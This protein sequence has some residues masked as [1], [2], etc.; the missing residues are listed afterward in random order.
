MARFLIGESS[1]I[2]IGRGLPR[3]LLPPSPARRRVAVLHQARSPSVADVVD[4][5]EAGGVAVEVID[6]PGGEEAKTLAAVEG[7]Y[8]RLA[9]FE[10]GRSDTVVTVGGGATTDAG[11]FVAATWLRGIEVVHVPTTL[12]AAVDAAIGGKTAVNLGGKNLVGAFWHPRRV[13]ID[14][15][16]LSG[17]PAALMRQGAAEAIKAGLIGAP[18]LVEEYRIHGLAAPL[19]EVVPP[20]VRVKAEIVSDDFTER[21]NRAWLNLGHTIG[22][23]IEFASGLSHGESVAIGLVA[24][25]AVSERLLGFDQTRYVV[26]TLERVGLPVRAPA[27]DRDRVLQ[28]VALDKKREA[29]SIRMVLLGDVGAPQVVAVGPEDVAHGLAAVGL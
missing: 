3:P 12:L 21:G 7:V 17:L 13:A 23:G 27:V 14:L 22:H 28:L 5:L 15:D 9:G 24:A 1:E 19:E 18:A 2:L 20:A 10:L 4:S 16:T 29:D 6:L 26:E 25:C 8:H 11:G